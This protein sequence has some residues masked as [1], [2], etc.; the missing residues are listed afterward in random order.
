MDRGETTGNGQGCQRREWVKMLAPGAVAIQ[1]SGRQTDSSEAASVR[2][3]I[4]Q[5]NKLSA[6]DS[7]AMVETVIRNLRKATHPASLGSHRLV[8][9]PSWSNP[10]LSSP[11]VP[12]ESKA[13]F[14]FLKFLR[15]VGPVCSGGAPGS[16]GE[17]RQQR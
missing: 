4:L 7:W 12:A 6:S 5:L 13:L 15:G 16:V 1:N 9:L 10:P 8:C 11:Q 2:S 14:K 17:R 3:L